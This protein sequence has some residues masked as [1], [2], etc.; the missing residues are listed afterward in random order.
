MAVI[1]FADAQDKLRERSFS[2]P[3]FEGAQRSRE[4]SDIY[5]QAF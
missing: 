4:A 1:A 3:L 2:T 5:F